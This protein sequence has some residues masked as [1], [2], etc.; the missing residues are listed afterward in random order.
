MC[1]GGLLPDIMHDLLEGALQYEV[2]LMLKSMIEDDEYFTLG[3]IITHYSDWIVLNSY[4]NY[5]IETFN[6]RMVNTELG[7]MEIKDKPTPITDTTI[8][9]SG[10]TLKQSGRFERHDF[11]SYLNMLCKAAQMWLLGRLLPLVIGDMV[12]TGD[13]KWENF[14]RVMR[15]V[16]LLF[17]P[18]ITEDLVGYLSRMI[19]EHH[20]E[21]TVL[22][23]NNSV[24]PKMHFMIHMPRLILR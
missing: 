16:D 11:F 19:E 14:L 21:F 13:G 2:K 7:Y 18:T 20:Q 10:H 1:D 8:S 4:S 23:P 15:I 17:S 3:I 9:S 6:V 24:I 12:P 22:Y 5:S